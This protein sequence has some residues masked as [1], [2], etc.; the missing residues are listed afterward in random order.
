VYSNKEPLFGEAHIEWQL[1]G[2]LTNKIP[3][4]RKLAWY[5]VTGGNGYYANNNLYHVEAFVGLDNLGY[6]AYRFFRLDYVH[7][8]NSLNQYTSA[9]RLGIS[10]NSLIRINLGENTDTEW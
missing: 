1:R 7:A 10:T 4:F 9:I 3:L 2:F 8:W 5:L 6:S